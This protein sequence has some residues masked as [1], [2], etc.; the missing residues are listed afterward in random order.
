MPDAF[1]SIIDKAA[2]LRAKEILPTTTDSRWSDE[3][4]VKCLKRLLA[5]KGRLSE[6]IIQ[7]AHRTPLADTVHKHLGSYAGRIYFRTVSPLPTF[8]EG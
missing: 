7:R 8:P 3:D 5:Q 4:F 2:F 1:V 6:S